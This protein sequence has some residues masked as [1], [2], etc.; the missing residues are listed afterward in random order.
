MYEKICDINVSSN[1]VTVSWGKLEHFKCLDKNI[2]EISL[3]LI[4]K[5]EEIKQSLTNFESKDLVLQNEKQLSCFPWTVH[6]KIAQ[7]SHVG[8]DGWI[9]K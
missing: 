4:Y 1:I 9:N 7:L 5:D 8:F 2:Q 3:R 6:I